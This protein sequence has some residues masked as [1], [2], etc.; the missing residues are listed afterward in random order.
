MKKLVCILAVA[1]CCSIGMGV[2]AIEP[3]T[4]EVGLAFS[5][6]GDK[7]LDNTEI[8]ATGTWGYF[9]TP[10]IEVGGLADVSYYNPEVG[11]SETVWGLG[12]FLNYHFMPET[13]TIPYIGA[14]VIYKDL[15]DIGGEADI[16]GSIL[17]GVKALITERVGFKIELA[18]TA[19]F[20]EF[21][22]G[23]WTI[24]G[25]FVVYFW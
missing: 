7:D 24:I 12:G 22:E 8:C 9:L 25:G 23:E 15:E 10:V 1:V 4:Q 5:F 13:M 19:L 17:G 6:W 16:Y 18:Y 21:D 14:A 11:D 20:D 2:Y 3:G